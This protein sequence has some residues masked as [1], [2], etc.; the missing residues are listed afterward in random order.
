MEGEFMWTPKLGHVTIVACELNEGKDWRTLLHIPSA[1]I[2]WVA[3]MDHRRTMGIIHTRWHSWI[4]VRL[5][6]CLCFCGRQW[7]SWKWMHV[8]F[9][10]L[11]SIELKS[12]MENA[13]TN[14]VKTLAPGASSYIMTGYYMPYVAEEKSGGRLRLFYSIELRSIVKCNSRGV[15]SSTALEVIDSLAI[16][17]GSISSFRNEAYLQ[18][19][20]SNPLKCQGLLQSLFPTICADGFDL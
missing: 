16:C 13:V 9:Y 7:S 18:V 8:E 12:R 5:G 11:N 10:R 17:G 14:I 2:T 19:S 6:C 4:W 15:P 20:R 3:D 1:P